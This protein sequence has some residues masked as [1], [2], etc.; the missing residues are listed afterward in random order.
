MILSLLFEF[1]YSQVTF[2]DLLQSLIFS[3]AAIL[4]AMTVHEFSHALAAYALG[5][6]T[7][8]ADGRLSFNPLH[9]L[10]PWG[11]LLLLLF[12]F[13]WAKPVNINYSQLKH[14]RSGLAITAAAGPL[15][16]LVTAFISV[17]F[18]VLAMYIPNY[19]VWYNLNEFLSYL[20]MFN[21]S[22]A[23]FNLIPIP[24]LDGSK[25]LGELL[26]AEARFKYYSIER[27][28]TII[29]L[30]IIILFDRLGIFSAL[31]MGVLN[32]IVRAVAGLF[33]LITG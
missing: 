26:P 7:A 19:T 14:R 2:L 28:S 22:L 3:F 5:D 30:A 15:S 32:V 16:N 11:L 9:H 13:G 18:I 29:L 8:K 24:P 4:I 27:Y 33:G 21:I 1:I 20:A 17:I 31:Q 6:K 25:I 12:G 10:D 23:V